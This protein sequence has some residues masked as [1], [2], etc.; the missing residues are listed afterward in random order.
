MKK[1]ENTP[2]E[3]EKKNRM[4]LKTNLPP[5]AEEKVRELRKTR[6]RTSKKK[7]YK[8]NKTKY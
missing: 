4:I 8:K 3:N 2:L 1:R 5:N 6:V 7:I